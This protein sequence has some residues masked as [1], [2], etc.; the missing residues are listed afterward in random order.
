MTPATNYYFLLNVTFPLKHYYK[1]I[2][3]PGFLLINDYII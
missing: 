2:K 3:I 1:Y